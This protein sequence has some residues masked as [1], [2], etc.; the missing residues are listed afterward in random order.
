MVIWSS[1][2]YEINTKCEQSILNSI[3]QT[4]RTPFV[5]GNYESEPMTIYIDSVRTTNLGK[6]YEVQIDVLS[7]AFY[8]R[9]LPTPRQIRITARIAVHFFSV[10]GW[11]PL[12]TIFAGQSNGGQFVNALD[13]TYE[14]K[15]N[16]P[17]SYSVLNRIFFNLREREDCLTTYFHS[18]K[19]IKVD[20]IKDDYINTATLTGNEL[21]ESYLYKQWVKDNIFGGRLQYFGFDIDGETVIVNTAG[22]MYSRQGMEQRPVKTVFKL[23]QSLLDC[24]A[25]TFQAPLTRF[26]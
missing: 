17:C 21:E 19:K 2:V 20:R 8:V 26:M 16:S 11:P 15:L 24:K 18:L 12:V 5:Y 6:L 25:I 22:Y 10:S 1:T 23:L 4:L 13:K 3:F 9:D 14:E 7:P